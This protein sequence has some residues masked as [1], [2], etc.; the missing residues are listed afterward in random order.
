M[1]EDRRGCHPPSVITNASADCSPDRVRSYY[2]AENLK[3][4]GAVKMITLAP[5]LPGGME[6]VESLSKSGTMVSI[7]HS[8]VDY[9]GAATAIKKGA[10]MITHLF[11]A[12]APLHHRDPGPFGTITKTRASASF[13][14]LSPQER[15]YFGIIA[16]GI[17]LHPAS[18]SLAF[19]AH[20]DGL[21][22]VT[23]AVRYQGCADGIYDWTNGQ[24]VQKKGPVIMLEEQQTIAG[25]YVPRQSFRTSYVVVKLTCEQRCD[26]D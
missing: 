18:V 20:P 5:E 7:G 21:V 15:P 13:Q 12:M 3:P 8:D 6:S 26:A 11:N 16:D 4:D 9:E 25:R 23:D 22:L 14:H 2:G 19:A 1:A 17:H 24:K 10:K